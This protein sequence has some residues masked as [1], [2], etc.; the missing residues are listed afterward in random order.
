MDRRTIRWGLAL[1][2]AT[3]WCSI[4]S[5]EPGVLV[6]G[7][8]PTCN[9][10]LFPCEG[11][12]FCDGGATCRQFGTEF[13]CVPST[14]T[15]FCCGTEADCPHATEADP[16]VR[17]CE[18]I[19][20]AQGSLCVADGESFCGSLSLEQI[21]LCYS[22]AAGRQTTYGNGD[23]DRD[24]IS[25][26]NEEELGTDECATPA[27]IGVA[28]ENGCV[29]LVTACQPGS[30]CVAAAA[31]ASTCSVT[32]DENGTFCDPIE[33][34]LFC[35]GGQF[36]CSDD[37]DACVTVGDGQFCVSLCAG[38][39]GIDPAACITGADGG[40]VPEALGDCDDDSIANS[41]D[42]TP[43]GSAEVDAGMV[44]TEDAS[45]AGEDAGT[46]DAGDDVEPEFAGGGGCACRTSAGS[47][48]AAMG[49]L[50]LSL[51]GLA[52]WRSRR[53]S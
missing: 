38:V 16:E 3:T 31:P 7:D 40:P 9:F 51:V 17:T 24:G 47:P 30:T 4:A 33:D 35:C 22:T 36:A 10:N 21:N 39:D 29:G 8:P 42:D 49:W 25:N 44:I 23:C 52:A 27:A 28:T 34:A 45:M 41:E 5:A 11:G 48:S 13:L 12:T 37:S 19:S 2:C 53:R 6:P 1:L 15:L 32:P 14:A 46:F 20:G 43:C 18:S 26:A 50:A